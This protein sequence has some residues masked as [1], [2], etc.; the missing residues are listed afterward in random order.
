MGNSTGMIVNGVTPVMDH[1]YSIRP[2]LTIER[3]SLSQQPDKGIRYYLVLHSSDGEQLI[4]NGY[5]SLEAAERQLKFILTAI[6]DQ[7]GGGTRVN[8]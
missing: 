4:G 7:L 2:V 6:G 1:I 8:S 3:R 5:D